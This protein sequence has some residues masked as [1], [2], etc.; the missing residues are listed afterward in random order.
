VN[1]DFYQRSCD[2]F[3]EACQL[4]VNEQGTFLESAC[5]GDADLLRNVEQMLSEDLRTDT[6]EPDAAIHR[7]LGTDSSVQSTESDF[8]E[9]S[10]HK[11]PKNFPTIAG[12][13]IT[14]QLG[15]GG[16]GVVYRA[17]QHSTDREVALKTLPYGRFTT[18]KNVERFEREVKLAASLNH[19]GIAQ[20]YDSGECDGMPWLAMELVDGVDLTAWLRTHQLDDGS[21]VQLMATVCNAVAYAHSRGIIH[22][23]LK[24]GNILVTDDGRPCVVDFGL[25]RILDGDYATS[26]SISVVGDML[27]TPGYMSPEQARGEAEAIDGRS[28]CYSLGVILYELLT[29]QPAHNVSGALIAVIRRIADTELPSP[30]QVCPTLDHDLESI[31]MKSVSPRP[32]DRYRT[33]EELGQDLHRFLSGQTLIA[34]RHSRRYL[35]RKWLVRHRRSITVLVTVGCIAV[36]GISYHFQTLTSSAGVSKP[37]LPNASQP[38]LQRISGSPLLSRSLRIPAVRTKASRIKRQVSPAWTASQQRG[39]CLVRFSNRGIMRKPG[40]PRSGTTPG[41]ASETALPACAT[42]TRRTQPASWELL[43]ASTANLIPL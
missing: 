17:L 43:F 35:L 22:R 24:P 25:A 29:G 33:V 32:E 8:Q 36:A 3:L 2:L 37:R 5:A 28:D 4:P 12:F 1:S 42:I 27:G 21:K 6:D 7:L 15:E 10:H 20:I 34:R 16:M 13:T 30:R 39:A 41:I 18:G 23:D 9:D 11:S 19:P 31:V 26:S 14:E 40:L 38:L